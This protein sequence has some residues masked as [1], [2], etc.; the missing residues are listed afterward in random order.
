MLVLKANPLS[1]SVTA[2]LL[3]PPVVISV[4][5]VAVGVV[6]TAL[7]LQE[8]EL[9]YTRTLG[10]NIHLSRVQEMTSFQSVYTFLVRV[11]AFFFNVFPHLPPLPPSPPPSLPLLLLNCCSL[12]SS[13]SCSLLSPMLSRK[14]DFLSVCTL[15]VSGVVI[16]EDREIYIPHVCM[17]IHV[18]STLV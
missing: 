12:L 9:Q 16:C 14:L 18:Y 10:N 2:V 1:F 7:Y 11:D 8:K 6:Q 3:P 13:A 5:G 17:E 15:L 4:V